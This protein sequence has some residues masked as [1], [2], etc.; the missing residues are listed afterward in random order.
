MAFS[1]RKKDVFGALIIGEAVAWLLVVMLRVNAPELPIPAGLAETLSAQSTAYALAVAFPILSV[2]GLAIA[3]VLSRAISIL[4]QV[5][6]FVLVGALNTFVDL[7][8]L[9]GF[10]LV[11]GVASGGGYLLFKTIAFAAA[12]TNSYFWNK[13]WTFESTG[14]KTKDEAVQFGLVSF[15]GFLLNVATAHIVVNIIG[16]QAGLA[17]GVWGNV[18][19][20]AAICIALFWNFF[21]YKLWVFK[22]R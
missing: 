12:L 7:G 4:Y 5:A 17:P 21:G 22:K 13:H 8:I 3:A 16:P 6:K 10:I 2:I 15:V 1:L 19:A 11:T 18:G 20:L 14:G 9:N